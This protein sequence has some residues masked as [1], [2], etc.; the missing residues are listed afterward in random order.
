VVVGINVQD[1]VPEA[2]RFLKET[3]TT[4]PVVRDRDNA[5]YRAYGVVALPETFFIDRDGKIVE[6][7]R[8]GVNDPQKWFEAVERALERP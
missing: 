3:R 7:S 1:L 4:Y 5:S 8:G 6:K 2:M